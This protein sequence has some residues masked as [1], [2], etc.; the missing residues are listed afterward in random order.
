[1]NILWPEAE[2]NRYV[3]DTSTAS[4]DTALAACDIELALAT[5]PFRKIPR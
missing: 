2:F 4:R 3:C 5:Q 1:M